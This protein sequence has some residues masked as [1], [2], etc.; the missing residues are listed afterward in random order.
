MAEITATFAFVDLAGF[1][2]LTDVHGDTEAAEL[3]DRFEALAVA[4]LGPDDRLVK[5]IGDAVFMTFANT[6]G[7]LR[8]VGQL[9]RACAAQPD[10]P[11]PRTGLHHGVAVARGDDLIG[12]D[13][14]T[15]ARIAGQAHGAQVLASTEVAATARAEGIHVVEL[16]AFDLRNLTNPVTLYQVDLFPEIAGSAIDPVCRMRVERSEAAGRLR[17]HDTDHWFC[18]LRCAA[19]FADQPD[20]YIVSAAP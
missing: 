2:A 12:G 19:L 15:A 3:I 14:N 16:G 11:L 10:F 6:A 7:A 20:N 17:H 8:S 1:T 18:S 4:A 5:S 13:V 9:L